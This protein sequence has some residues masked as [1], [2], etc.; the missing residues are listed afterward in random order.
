MPAG[1]GILF[2]LAGGTLAEVEIELLGDGFGA[3]F[4]ADLYDGGQGGAFGD[5]LVADEFVAVLG[6]AQLGGGAP[7][8]EGDADDLLAGGDNF[9]VVVNETDL[10]L[11]VLVHEELGTGFDLGEEPAAGG[12]GF[13]VLMIVVV[14]AGGVDREGQGEGKESGEELG[15]HGFGMGL[16]VY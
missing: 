5:G 13:G 9:V 10:D 8:S 12:A 6:E 2:V 14:L 4:G 11:V 3:L 15:F 1:A 16:L 7:V